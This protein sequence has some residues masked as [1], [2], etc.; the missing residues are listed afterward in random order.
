MTLWFDDD[1]PKAYVACLRGEVFPFALMRGF[2]AAEGGRFKV[3]ERILENAVC[4]LVG[5]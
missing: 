3:N 5:I 2:M 1:T 4:V